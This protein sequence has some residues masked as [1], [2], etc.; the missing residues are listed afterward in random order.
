VAGLQ[1]DI[2]DTGYVTRKKGSGTKKYVVGFINAQV[3]AQLLELKHVDFQDSYFYLREFFYK[4]GF[5]I[6]RL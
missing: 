5:Y 4:M 6:R 2:N 1:A 3:S